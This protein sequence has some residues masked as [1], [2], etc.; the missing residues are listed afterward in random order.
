M[1][2]LEILVTLSCASTRHWTLADVLATIR[3]I[4][5]STVQ[6]YLDLLQSQGLLVLDGPGQYRFAPTTTELAA[7]VEGLCTAYNRRPV[8]LIRT[9][10][11]IADSRK[12]QSFAAAFRLR[13]ER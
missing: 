6:Q 3:P 12:I 11:T 2:A 13:K 1:D 9:V 4:P 7:A 10:Y 8:T 5:A